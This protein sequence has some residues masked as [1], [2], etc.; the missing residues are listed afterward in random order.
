MK[1]YGIFKGMVNRLFWPKSR[2]KEEQEDDNE[3]ER[4][5]GSDHG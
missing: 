4:C 2:R 3:I 5:T 1:I